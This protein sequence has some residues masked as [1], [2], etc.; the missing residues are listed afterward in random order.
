MR[1]SAVSR[2]MWTWFLVAV[3]VMLVHKVECY[4]GEEWKVS[5]FFQ[6]LIANGPWADASREDA[7]GE[8]IFLSF[9]C[10]LFIGLF[11][12][13]TLMLGGG[14]SL[15]PLGIW[16]LT[17]LLETHHLWRSHRAGEAYVGVWT[18]ILYLPVMV[19]YW[20]ELVRCV[21]AWARSGAGGEGVTPTGPVG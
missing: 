14:W 2:T 20:V 13:A 3:A 21:R 5:P 12:G 11:M 17:L 16:G 19:R 9:V 4:A 7:L 15:V 1:E 18:S 6:E 10:W 8:A